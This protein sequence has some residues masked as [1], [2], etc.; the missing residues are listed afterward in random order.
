MWGARGP[1]D[2]PTVENGGTTTANDLRSGISGV[3]LDVRVADGAGPLGVDGWYRKVCPW[4][5]PPGRLRY[6]AGVVH[7]PAMIGI[8]FGCVADEF[9]P[10]PPSDAS[11][12]GP[13][14]RQLTGAFVTW[15][16]E[17]G[18]S[19]SR[20][21]QDTPP[22]GP[23]LEVSGQGII[24]F[25]DDLGITC[26]GDNDYGQ[27]EGPAGNFLQVSA[28]AWAACAV[29]SN[30][31]LWCWGVLSEP[32]IKSGVARV[33]VGQSDGACLIDL[34]GR[35]W[36]WGQ[37]LDFWMPDYPRSG[38]FVDVAVGTMVSCALTVDGVATCWGV[39]DDEDPSNVPNATTPY[40]MVTAGDDIGCALTT[41]GRAECWQDPANQTANDY[42]LE[43][44]GYIEISATSGY[45]VCGLTPDH[46]PVCS[47]DD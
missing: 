27:A 30:H 3:S 6:W 41:D 21:I 14:G 35:L 1:A 7:P 18:T 25:R 39:I 10:A 42:D 17:D 26:W 38:E 8:L 36:C 24:C 13:V 44:S 16:H 5:A 47:D 29:D 45:M 2:L 28:G 23:W 12:E 32:P 37:N 4:L 31:D 33:A 43:G 20:T 40:T 11:F 34:T 19:E 22:V 15:L 46:V 9:A